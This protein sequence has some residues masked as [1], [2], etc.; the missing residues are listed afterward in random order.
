M[1]SL[2]LE[3]RFGFIYNAY[4]A[5]TCDCFVL[6]VLIL[7]LWPIFILRFVFSLLFLSFIYNNVL[8]FNFL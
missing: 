6:E 8:F 1:L 4:L 7:L 5:E 2:L 3:A